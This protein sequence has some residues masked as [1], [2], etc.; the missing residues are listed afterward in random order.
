VPRE[1]LGG[2]RVKLG[3]TKRNEEKIFTIPFYK[4]NP[5]EKTA[6]NSIHKQSRRA[7]SLKGFEHPA[8]KEGET[9]AAVRP[10]LGEQLRLAAR[11][12][13][14]KKIT[15]PSETKPQT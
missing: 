8:G 15:T 14:G 1:G 5:K 9:H 4:S 10:G 7:P 2:T 11:T 12:N 6:P 13:S 3:R